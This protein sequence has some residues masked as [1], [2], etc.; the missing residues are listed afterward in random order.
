MSPPYTDTIDFNLSKVIW[1]D[2]ST[3]ALLSKDGKKSKRVKIH[4]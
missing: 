3:V 2:N 1:K 4:A